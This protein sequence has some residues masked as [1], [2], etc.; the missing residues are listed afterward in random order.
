MEIQDLVTAVKNDNPT[1]FRTAFDSVIL[2]RVAAA[3]ADKKVEVAQ[4][5]V[6]DLAT[7]QNTETDEGT[8]DG[9]DAETDA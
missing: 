3:I 8:T 6:G 9:Q 5:L 2:D 4:S 7:E 1:D